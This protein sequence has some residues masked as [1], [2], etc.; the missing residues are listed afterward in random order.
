[1]ADIMS[2]EKRSALMS[3]IRGKNTKPE[4]AL[5]SALHRMGLRFRIHYDLPGRPDIVFVKAKVAIFVDGCFWHG[6]RWH[7]VMPKGNRQFWAEKIG[8]NKARDRRSSRKLRQQSWRVIRIW[9]H[10]ITANPTAV[11]KG[12]SEIVREPPPW[13]SPPRS[14]F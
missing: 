3:R 9:E 7:G 8:A 2:K 12:V 14:N 1:M 13:L 11:A 10:S 4:V 6:C 5:R